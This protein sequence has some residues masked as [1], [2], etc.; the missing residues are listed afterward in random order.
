[1]PNS[2][3]AFLSICLLFIT[4]SCIH[5]SKITKLYNNGA[6]LKSTDVVL[7][8]GFNGEHS[9]TSN[10]MMSQTER[11][12]KKYGVK[13]HYLHTSNFNSEIVKAGFTATKA[14]IR[15]EDFL[16][17]MNQVYGL[18]YI[19]TVS[20]IRKYDGGFMTVDRNSKMLDETGVVFEVYSVTDRQVVASMQLSGSTIHLY[21]I[22]E[23]EEDRTYGNIYKNYGKGLRKLMK[24]SKY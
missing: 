14:D 8:T 3:T 6:H 13:V 15:N 24:A 21:S 7:F 5:T 12:L 17:K 2:T 10:N 18:S 20:D 19:F 22:H 11:I 4:S 1:M 9:R 23:D 16:D